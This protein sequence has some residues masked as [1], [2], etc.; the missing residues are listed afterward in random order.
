MTSNTR[1]W[2]KRLAATAA[3]ATVAVGLLGT[4]PAARADDH[5][6]WRNNNWHGDDDWDHGS[7]YSRQYYYSSP[8]TYYY[9]PPPT[10]YYPPPAYY[11]PP[12]LNF[13][14]SF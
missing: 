9:V 2:M 6:D 14:F 1:S 7:Y 4:A 5:G 12:V 3:M 11:G 8:P 13:G 10:Y